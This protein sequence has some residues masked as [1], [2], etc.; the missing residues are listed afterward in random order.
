M[1]IPGRVHEINSKAFPPRRKY[2]GLSASTDKQ[3]TSQDSIQGKPSHLRTT[4][5]VR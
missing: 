3:S 2:H 5:S 1:K 4:E